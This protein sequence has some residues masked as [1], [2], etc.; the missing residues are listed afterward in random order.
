MRFMD[1]ALRLNC[2]AFPLTSQRNRSLEVIRRGLQ[3]VVGGDFIDSLCSVDERWD[4]RRSLKVRD[5]LSLH[6]VL[7]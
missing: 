5:A 4:R 7:D 1:L 3:G 2:E 6:D